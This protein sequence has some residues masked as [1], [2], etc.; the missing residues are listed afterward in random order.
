MSAPLL[1]MPRLYYC[2]ECL[3]YC[4]LDC[5]Y[6]VSMWLPVQVMGLTTAIGVLEGTNSPMF[7][8][9]LV[10]SLIVSIAALSMHACAAGLAHRRHRAALPLGQRLC[11]LLQDN[12]H[13]LSALAAP[14][15]GHV[16]CQRR[17]VACWQAG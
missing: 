6:D 15:A 12:S 8:I 16:R 9:S 5:S 2:C 17:A 4:L 7:A 14:G 3:M 10:F 1:I 11:L 13:A